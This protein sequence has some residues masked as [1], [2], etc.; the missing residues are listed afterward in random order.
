MKG[1]ESGLSNAAHTHTHTHTTRHIARHIQQCQADLHLARRWRTRFPTGLASAWRWALRLKLHYF[2]LEIL[3]P[4]SL[5]IEQDWARFT[6]DNAEDMVGFSPWFLL[7][8]PVH[9]L[10]CMGQRSILLGLLC[11]E[12][13]GS[14]AGPHGAS[15]RCPEY[16][17]AVNLKRLGP[18][19]R[20]GPGAGPS[21][22]PLFRAHIKE[23]ERT[24]SQRKGACSLQI[25][26]PCPAPESCCRRARG[27]F[28]RAAHSIRR[29]VGAR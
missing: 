29:P 24:F 12:R 11:L 22:Q 1:Q 25:G 18:A 5:L 26:R 10:V 13:A 23:S 21:H 19:A 3:L 28:D 9:T 2:P 17:A 16:A 15:A 4:L 14:A 27:P 7:S 6:A 20:P 8:W